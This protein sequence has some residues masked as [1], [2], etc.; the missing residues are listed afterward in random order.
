MIVI[1]GEGVEGVVGG[2]ELCPPPPHETTSAATGTTNLNPRN[3]DVPTSR[4]IRF[5][6]PQWSNMRPH[7]GEVKCRAGGSRMRARSRGH[8]AEGSLLCFCL[9]AST[10]HLHRA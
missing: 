5:E 8:G 3:S 6:E 4:N 1:A 7:P 10:L 9:S 2:V